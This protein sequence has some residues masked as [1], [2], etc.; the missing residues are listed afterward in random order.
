MWLWKQQL[1]VS[2]YRLGADLVRKVHLLRISSGPACSTASAYKEGTI[3]LCGFSHSEPEPFV[4]L[5][6]VKNDSYEKGNDLVVVHVYVKEI[7]KEV[8]KVL[9]REQDFT[10]MFQTRY[11][12]ASGQRQAAVQ[13]LAVTGLLNC[14]LLNCSQFLCSDTNFLRLHPGCGP[15]TVF[16]WQVKLRYSSPPSSPHEPTKA[17]G[18]ELELVQAEGSVR[19]MLI[20]TPE[21]LPCAALIS[22]IWAALVFCGGLQ[23]RKSWCLL[24][25]RLPPGSS[26]GFWRWSQISLCELRAG[27]PSGGGMG[28]QAEWKGICA[29]SV[30]RLKSFYSALPSSPLDQC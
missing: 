15:H 5:S 28:S 14:S 26:K 27:C 30:V 4:S 9:F 12:L 17:E 6:F 8:S 29:L 16:R 22:Q 20:P 1:M 7:H 21:G 10:L 25:H 23:G 24:A 18:T 3:C 19:G 13:F 2:G 11:W